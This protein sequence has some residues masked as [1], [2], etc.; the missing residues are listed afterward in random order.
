[1]SFF[2]INKSLDKKVLGHYPQIK[3]IHH[4]CH[5]WDEPKF[6]EHI[7]FTKV[8][9]EPIT[10][11]A[12]LHS[13][14]K[15]TDLIAATGMGFTLK[16]LLSGKLK[17]ILEKYKLNG[18]Q[19]FKSPI[20]QNNECNDDYWVLNFYISNMDYVDFQKS[21]IYLTENSFNM[22]ERLYLNNYEEYTLKKQEIEKR[23]YPYGILIDK[24][25]LN[26]DIHDDFFL[27]KDVKGGVKYITSQKLKQEIEDAGC[28][29]IEFQPVEL[30]YNEW[31]APGGEREKV[32]GK[33]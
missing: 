24:F 1:M 19:F 33:F 4:N 22:I 11:N 29:G 12:Y 21:E 2:I 6:I 13:K 32:Y 31:T 25:V 20:I 14:A 15:Q 30:S 10:S 8:D 23:G 7:Y 9:F 18:L 27:L 26:C 17:S 3:D 5:I 28:T 16:L